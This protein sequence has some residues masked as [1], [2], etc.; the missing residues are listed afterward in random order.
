M[1]WGILG[2]MPRTPAPG[3]SRPCSSRSVARLRTGGRRPGSVRARLG[4]ALGVLGL[5]ALLVVAGAP[6]AQA[7]NALRETSPADGSTVPYTP[8]RVTLTFDAPATALGT[9]LVVTA[10]DGTVVSAG[11]AELVDST[12]AQPLAGTLPAGAYTVRWR[13]TSADGHPIEGTFGF[14]A[15]QATVAGTGGAPPAVDEPEPTPTPTDAE[16]T[17]T[18]TPAAEADPS[19]SASPTTAPD[20]GAAVSGPVLVGVAV[21]VVAVGAVVAWLLLR[22]RPTA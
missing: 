5:G 15:E 8:D 16:V 17:P 13:V 18:P 6:A 20:D 12:V 2:D 21:A 11:P 3:A 1:R 9:E 4:A 10:A 22:R 19:P 14:V 7:H